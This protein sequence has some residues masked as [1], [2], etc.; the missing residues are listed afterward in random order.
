MKRIGTVLLAFLLVAVVLS[1]GCLRG[2]SK[3]GDL[4]GGD[5]CDKL[6]KTLKEE[7]GIKCD[8]LPTDVVPEKLKNKT[9]IQGKCY[10]KCVSGEKVYNISVVESETQGTKIVR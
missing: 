1:S 2:V 9:G 8:C 10:C 3:I 6:E 7:H 5:K 4:V